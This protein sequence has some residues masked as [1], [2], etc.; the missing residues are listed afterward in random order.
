MEERT[1]EKTGRRERRER[2][3]EGTERLEGDLFYSSLSHYAGMHISISFS[4]HV[5]IE[6]KK[7]AAQQ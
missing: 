3:E 1:E 6:H 4:S 7:L 5:S 2:R